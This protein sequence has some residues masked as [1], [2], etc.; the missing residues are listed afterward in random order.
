MLG[1]KS[2]DIRLLS[3]GKE[4][5]VHVHVALRFFIEA[6]CSK[7][8]LDGLPLTIYFEDL[9]ESDIAF[10]QPASQEAVGGIGSRLA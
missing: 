9:H 7:A 1:I 5:Q 4:L 10:G 3:R 6:M 8:N 2:D